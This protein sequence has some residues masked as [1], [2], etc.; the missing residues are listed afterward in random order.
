VAD[1]K[2]VT[3]GTRGTLSCLDAA[4]GKVLWRKDD[5]KGAF[6]KFFTSSSP[7]VVDGLCVAQLGSRNNGGVVAYDLASGEQKWKWT[8]DGPAYAS[9]ALM[10][11]GEVKHIVAMTEGKIVALGAAD[12]KLVWETPFPA[13]AGPGGYNASTPIVDGQTIIYGGG[14]RGFKAVKLEKTG[15]N[16]TAKELWSHK[17]KSVQFNTPVLKDGVLYGLTQGN[18]FVCINAHDGKTMWAASPL[19]PSGGGKGRGRG[20]YGSI[21]DAG[22][23]LL[24]LTPATDLVVFQPSDKSYTELA[25]IKVADTP[26]YAYPVVSGNRLFIKDQNSLTLW[27]VE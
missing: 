18:E 20:G 16:V 15:D 12:G 10:M 2:V 7:V 24:A 6:P 17:E 14:G 1:G 25:R 21:V 9:L 26:T 4:S 11:L 22:S 23:V 19:K 8:G 5:F 3:F 27:T 13:P